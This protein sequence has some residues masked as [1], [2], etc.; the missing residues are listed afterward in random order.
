MRTRSAILVLAALLGA[1][2]AGCRSGSQDDEPLSPQDSLATA[3]EASESLAGDVA[4]AA[5]QTY[6]YREL[7]AG[8]SRRALETRAPADA[9]AGK[10]VCE[11]VPVPE[12]KAHAAQPRTPLAPQRHC[13][14]DA[15]F[16]RDGSPAH[17]EVTYARE[18]GGEVAR[19][20]IVSRDLPLDVDG[21]RLARTIATAFEQQ[22]SVLDRRDESFEGHTA[23][24]RV[25]ATSG[26][27]QNFAEVTVEPRGGRERLTVRLSRAPAGASGS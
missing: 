8:M 1:A 14:F 26:T 17:V 15:R 13:V 27:R 10:P 22:T 19:E 11:D 5:A 25:G 6:S 4:D 18:H 23:H 7:Y 21:L 20:I 16:R 24:I 2:G 12:P 3:R 9:E